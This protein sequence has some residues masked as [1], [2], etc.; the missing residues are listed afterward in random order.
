M[1]ISFIFLKKTSV[2][3]GVCMA[4]NGVYLPIDIFLSGLIFAVVFYLSN[5]KS[6]CKALLTLSLPPVPGKWLG[7]N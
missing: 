4:N 7:E 5:P 6:H 1:Y 2:K 3:W